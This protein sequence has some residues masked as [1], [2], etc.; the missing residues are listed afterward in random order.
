VF[1]E[2]GKTAQRTSLQQVLGEIISKCEENR[3]Q[4]WSTMLKKL[5]LPKCKDKYISPV[6]KDDNKTE[7][8][9]DQAVERIAQNVD[10]KAQIIAAAPGMGKSRCA[11]EMYPRFVTKLEDHLVYL[12]PLIKSA[13]YLIHK[14]EEHIDLYNDEEA[15][16][17]IFGKVED[18]KKQNWSENEKLFFWTDL[19]MTRFLITLTFCLK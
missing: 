13:N 14:N 17:F 5:D 15:F 4:M 2:S 1:K 19:T 7:L 10:Q 18:Q 12:V 9:L 16:K 6:L 8:Q 11:Q 3:S